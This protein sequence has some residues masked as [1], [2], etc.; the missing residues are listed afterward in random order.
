MGDSAFIRNETVRLGLHN[1]NERLDK[2]IYEPIDHL[3]Y[4]LMEIS[5]P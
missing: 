4:S 2:F 5:S 1:L 3:V